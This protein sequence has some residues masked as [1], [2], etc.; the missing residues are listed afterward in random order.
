MSGVD[1]NFELQRSMKVGPDGQVHTERFASSSVGDRALIDCVRARP[2]S[3]ELSTTREPKVQH[4]SQRTHRH[5]KVSLMNAIQLISRRLLV[6][7]ELLMMITAMKCQSRH[8]GRL[9]KNER[10]TKQ[11]K[12]YGHH[13]PQPFCRM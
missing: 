4:L 12:S 10:W 8:K 2:Q 5:N 9:L 7:H 6:Q 1:P 11:Q 13:C 3:W